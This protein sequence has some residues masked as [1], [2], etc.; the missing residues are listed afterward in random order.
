MKRKDFIKI[1]GPA[2]L[3]LANGRWFKA[4]GNILSPQRKI[5]FR[6]VVA[7][8][9]HYGQKD[10]DYERYFATFVKRVNEEH[11]K[12]GFAFCMFNGDIIH[13]DD[14]FFT[15]AKAALDELLPKYY[16]TLGNHDHA[17]PERWESVWKLPLNYDFEMMDTAFIAATTS[18]EKGEYICP[19]TTWIGQRLEHYKHH[20]RVFLFLHINPAKLTDNGIDCPDLLHMLSGY[21]NVRAVFNGHDHHQDGIKT[22]N[23][24]SFIFDAHIGSNWGTAYRG[25]RIVEIMEDDSILTYIMNPSEK[26]NI[27]H[28]TDNQHI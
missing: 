8:D 23:G 14:S 5:L 21:R 24:V 10:T 7:S 27:A 26:I 25:F 6:F 22:A 9:G 18:N 16:V 17:T 15:P 3:L 2:L 13:D 12:Q 28:V 19:D 1:T 20:K 11:R 4:N